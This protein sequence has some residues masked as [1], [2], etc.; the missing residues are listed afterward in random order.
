MTFNEVP[1]DKKIKA[2]SDNL[3]GKDTYA[4]NSLL[5]MDFEFVYDE[6][7][8]I[9]SVS[10]EEEFYEIWN[11]MYK[12][13]FVGKSEEDFLQYYKSEMMRMFRIYTA[14]SGIMLDTLPNEVRDRYGDFFCDEDTYNGMI[15]RDLI[16]QK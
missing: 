9:R 7:E 1:V 5:E 13:L 12:E 16:R 14:N 2:I 8:N 3:I 15:R 4:L 10:S 11:E 6:D